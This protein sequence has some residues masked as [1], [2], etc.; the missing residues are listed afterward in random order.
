MRIFILAIFCVVLNAGSI[1]KIDIVVAKRGAMGAYIYGSDTNSVQVS[2]EGQIIDS[3][4]IDGI[5]NPLDRVVRQWA[6]Q[7][8]LPNMAGKVEIKYFDLH[9]KR[10]SVFKFIE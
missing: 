10:Q 1:S 7:C 5:K 4:R 6:L 2:F 8:R 3:C 9:N